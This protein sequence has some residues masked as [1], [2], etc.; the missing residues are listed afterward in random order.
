M[1][2][3]FALQSTESFSVPGLY[4]FQICS[5]NL[6]FAI[7]TGFFGISRSGCVSDRPVVASFAG[8]WYDSWI[9]RCFKRGGAWNKAERCATSRGIGPG[10]PV[11]SCVSKPSLPTAPGR[12][13]SIFASSK[14]SGCASSSLRG[15]LPNSFICSSRSAIGFCFGLKRGCRVLVEVSQSEPDAFLDP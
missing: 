5:A 3:I 13:I 8:N 15:E 11:S 6:L 10:K 9:S 2:C 4:I 14:L 1:Y 7:C 12:Y